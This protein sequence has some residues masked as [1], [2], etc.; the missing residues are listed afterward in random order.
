MI[1]SPFEITEAQFLAG[2]GRAWEDLDIDDIFAKPFLAV[3][4]DWSVDC[5]GEP[6]HGREL[7]ARLL[8]HP[9]DALDFATPG[10]V[11]IVTVPDPA[12]GVAAFCED[13]LVGLYVG[14]D[15]VVHEDYR[16]RGIGTCLVIERFSRFG[17]LP[18]WELDV[19]AYSRA[20]LETH[21]SAFNLLISIGGPTPGRDDQ[22][23]MP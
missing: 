10:R 9:I 7:E 6:G 20:G 3:V 22:G 2:P 21:R 19:P 14:S 1:S 13:K 18:T 8:S 11:T 16:R 12:C 15:L 17:N 5:L 23:P 4:D